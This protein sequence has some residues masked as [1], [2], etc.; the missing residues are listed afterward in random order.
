MGRLL[1]TS[2]CS[3][4][5]NA[6]RADN[7]A[8]CDLQFNKVVTT[9]VV[10]DFNINHNPIREIACNA[11]GQACVNYRSISRLNADFHTLTCAFTGNSRHGTTRL[12]DL[13]STAQ[14]GPVESAHN[15]QGRR[16]AIQ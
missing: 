14:D 11:F 10:D 16:V 1:K 12:E 7:G 9:E 6:K 5:A 4:H 3:N 13:G 2:F 8:Y 15:S